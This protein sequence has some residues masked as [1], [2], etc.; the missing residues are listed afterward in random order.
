MWEIKNTKNWSYIQFV[1]SVHTE[2]AHS[3]LATY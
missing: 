1:Y 2:A 3:D